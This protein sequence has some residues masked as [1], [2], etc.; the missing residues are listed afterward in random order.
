MLGQRPYRADQIFK[1]VYSKRAASIDEMTD[2]SK[3]LR[4]R[5]KERFL[6]KGVD[7]AQ[8]VESPDGTRKFA[9]PLS[10]GA[11]IE[12][13]LIPDEGRV[14]LCV[15]SQAGCAVKCAFCATGGM[16]LKRNLKLFEL[17]GQVFSA[18][19][20]IAKRERITNVVLMGMGEPLLNYRNVV[21]LASILTDPRGFGLSRNKVT[22][23]TSGYVPGIKR[24]Q[25]DA[26]VN[27]AIS[28]NATTDRVRDAI[29][30]INRRYP[31]QILLDAVRG[32]CKATKR[33]VTI[34][35][36]LLKG[37]ND[38]VEDSGRLARLLKGTPCKVNLIPFNPFPG[39]V[40]E[41]PGDATVDAFAKALRASKYIVV[42]RASK[43]SDILAGCGTLAGFSWEGPFAEEKGVDQG[44][45]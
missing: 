32:Y 27:L 45:A 40:F 6:I 16:G 44:I 31:I 34:E 38:S 5:L 13:V 22:I 18:M 35:Y 3:D 12:S 10:D 17:T 39:S 37:V 25:R 36:V 1:W 29:M 28:L 8:V 7:R 14:T 24:L 9:T 20:L 15:S 42:R 26:D 33:H 2:I 23:S 19:G 43:G 21:N 30:P 4:E 41:R 11:I